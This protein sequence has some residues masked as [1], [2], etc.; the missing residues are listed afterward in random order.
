MEVIKLRVLQVS[1]LNTYWTRARYLLRRY[2]TTH[3]GEA[4]QVFPRAKAHGMHVF[5]SMNIHVRMRYSCTNEMN[6]R[7]SFD[8]MGTW[9]FAIFLMQLENIRENLPWQQS[10]EL[11]SASGVMTSSTNSRIA[12][13]RRRW[14]CL[15]DDEHWNPNGFA[16]NF[17]SLK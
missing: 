10:V 4:F 8:Y 14:L 9:T 16:V 13:C 17:T 1:K 12:A 7:H 11:T 6:R 5:V 15:D 3:K 2:D